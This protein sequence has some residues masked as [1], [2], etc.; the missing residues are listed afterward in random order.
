MVW[1]IPWIQN[2]ETRVQWRILGRRC[3]EQTPLR[4]SLW[5]NK[6]KASS[7]LRGRRIQGPH[8]DPAP[9]RCGEAVWADGTI[10]DPRRDPWPERTD[11]EERHCG[12]TDH[13]PS[14]GSEEQDTHKRI[15]WYI[16]HWEYHFHRNIYGIIKVFCL[17]ISPR[18][19][20][21]DQK[22]SKTY[23]EY[24]EISHLF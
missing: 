9:S 21:F 10:T 20:L 2:Y 4:S 11:S 24:C 18:L 14:H 19:H 17:K 8:P 5:L 22:Y 7:I 23:Y 12:S 15:G 13:L 1:S 3:H 16:I 6:W